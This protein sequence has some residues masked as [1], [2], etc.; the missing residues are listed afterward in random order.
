MKI[1]VVQRKEYTIYLEYAFGVH[2]LHTDIY[3]WTAGIKKQYIKELD[4]LR[5]LVGTPLLALVEKEDTKLSKFG[6]SLG[7]KIEREH[8]LDNGKQAYIYIWS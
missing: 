3:K 4:I 7:W 1:P 8:R 5:N 6:Q 2:W